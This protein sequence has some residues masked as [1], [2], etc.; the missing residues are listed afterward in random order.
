MTKVAFG[1]LLLQLLSGMG[2]SLEI[3]ILT[4]IFSIPLGVLV[5]C[6]RLSKSK[7]LSAIIRVYITI[8]RGTPLILQLYFFY[9]VPCLMLGLKI[10]KMVAIVFAMAI[11]YA[12][13]FAEIFRSGYQG[14]PVGLKEAGKILGFSKKQVFFTIS[15]PLVTKRVLPPFAGEVIT[16]VKDTAL[17]SALGVL[18][19]YKVAQNVTNR[20]VSPLPLV[21]AGVFYFV[22]NA[23]VSKGFSLL[24]KHLD[25]Y[26]F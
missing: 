5:T 16:L 11:N 6:G 4:L 7:V 19:L 13:Y 3:F 24:E 17:V 8:M 10:D 1:K 22:F 18:E 14:I 26:K 9:F 23:L 21:V 25:Y 12:A 2:V 20:M 15:L